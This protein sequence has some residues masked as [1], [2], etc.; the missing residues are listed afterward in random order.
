MILKKF[1]NNLSDNKVQIMLIKFYKC[2]NKENN[3]D[4]I[5][6]AQKKIAWDK[7]LSK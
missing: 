1:K 3:R 5:I 7:E 2:L 6:Y 4:S